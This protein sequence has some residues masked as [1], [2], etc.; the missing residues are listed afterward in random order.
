MFIQNKLFALFGVET[1]S[2]VVGL[3]GN[4]HGLIK[5]SLGTH[6]FLEGRTITKKDVEIATL[7]CS[8]EF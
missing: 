7:V 4:F 5:G 2:Q 1:Q 8:K 6:G 3:M